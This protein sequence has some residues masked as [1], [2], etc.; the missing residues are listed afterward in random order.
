MK[1]GKRQHHQDSFLASPR[2]QSWYIKHISSVWEVLFSVFYALQRSLGNLHTTPEGRSCLSIWLLAAYM[3]WEAKLLGQP[4]ESRRPRFSLQRRSHGFP[5]S[6]SWSWLK[7]Q[8][9][10]ADRRCRNLDLSICCDRFSPSEKVGV[11]REVLRSF[12]AG[13]AASADSAVDF[14]FQYNPLD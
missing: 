12:T 5:L 10:W 4:E 9:F 8:V 13:A 7:I 1:G 14:S 2:I 3:D 6:R 11:W